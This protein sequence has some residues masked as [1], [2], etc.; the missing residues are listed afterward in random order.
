MRNALEMQAEDAP[1]NLSGQQGQGGYFMAVLPVYNT[2]VV[3][4]ANVYFKSDSYEKM[5]G[6][7][8][9]IDEKVTIVIAKKSISQKEMDENSFYPIGVSG[10]I[11]E[12]NNNG[13]VVI[14]TRY[15][16]NI[17][18]VSVYKDYMID[19][20][21]S[22]RRDIEDIEEREL[23]AKV[24]DI[25]AVMLRFSENFQQASMARAYISQLYTIGEIISAM[26]PW[27]MNSNS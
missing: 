6:K 5:T 7:A 16:V 15:R 18:E 25:K 23:E 12:I 21:I 10:V 4:D 13:Y 22:K 19:L 24:K 11:T 1:P 2:L 14:R 3:P 17:E 20:S 9:S 8:P 26:S 27:I